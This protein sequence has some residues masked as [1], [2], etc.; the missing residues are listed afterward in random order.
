[1]ACQFFWGFFRR[2]FKGLLFRFDKQSKTTL[3]VIVTKIAESRFGMTGK[4]K[5]HVRYQN[6]VYCVFFITRTPPDC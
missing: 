6:W 4:K 5:N 1:M 3:S 2:F